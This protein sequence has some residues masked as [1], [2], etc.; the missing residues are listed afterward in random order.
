MPGT[1]NSL[2]ALKARQRKHKDFKTLYYK[3]NILGLQKFS[4]QIGI[5]VKG[6]SY[7]QLLSAIDAMDP[8]EFGSRVD[9]RTLEQGERLDQQDP[10][11]SLKLLDLEL[12]KIQKQADRE[13]RRKEKRIPKGTKLGNLH[14]LKNEQ[15]VQKR[16][17]ED[18]SRD[19]INKFARFLN[20]R[21]HFP[22]LYKEADEKGQLRKTFLEDFF[23]RLSPDE[24]NEMLLDES[25]GLSKDGMKLYLR[26]IRGIEPK[27]TLKEMLKQLKDHNDEIAR[28]DGKLEKG[29]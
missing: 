2:R 17:Y 13:T 24:F 3:L 4:N 21:T 11:T 16:N 20:L 7:K 15:N 6:K 10:K 27:N 14:I 18:M 29:D 25:N 22:D 28:I 12:K 23:D 8:A 26:H 19:E 1:D 9:L 5:D